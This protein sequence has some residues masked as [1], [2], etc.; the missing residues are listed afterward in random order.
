MDESTE[1][2]MN[3][4]FTAK[5]NVPQACQHIGLMNCEAEWERTKIMFRKYCAIR[6][7]DHF[8]EH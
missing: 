5:W 2:A 6:A 1:F 3:Q 4:L 7:K 8:G